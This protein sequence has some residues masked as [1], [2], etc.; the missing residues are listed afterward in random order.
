MVMFFGLNLTY[1]GTALA[2]YVALVCV[3]AGR[4]TYVN[5]SVNDS[6]DAIDYFAMA[7]MSPIFILHKTSVWL[8]ENWEWLLFDALPKI[9]NAIYEFVAKFVRY[10]VIKPFRH[11]CFLVNNIV[12]K[13]GKMIRDLVSPALEWLHVYVFIP[14]VDVVSTV[15]D[16]VSTV[17]QHL[18]HLFRDLTKKLIELTMDLL[19][20]LWNISYWCVYKPTKWMATNVIIPT[21]KLVREFFISVS[22]WLYIHVYTPLS[23]AI[24]ELV[25]DLLNFL[26]DL[27]YW[28]V[29]MPTKWVIINVVVPVIEWLHVYVYIPLSKL[30]LLI[31]DLTKKLAELIMNLLEFISYLLLNVVVP[32]IEWIE[33]LLPVFYRSIEIYVRY[34]WDGIYV[35]ILYP[36]YYWLFYYPIYELFYLR[37]L[38]VL[39]QMMQE[40]YGVFWEFGEKC[41]VAFWT[42]FWE[43][44]A[45][46]VKLYFAIFNGRFMHAWD[47]L[48]NG[49]WA[50][51]DALRS[52]F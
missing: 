22:E 37:L 43:L 29:Y 33:K 7:I 40:L 26:S 48:Y 1:A 34:I 4:F 8:K 50:F 16:V 18:D 2:V 45:E 21:V 49:F 47:R 17:L 46:A 42:L 41:F 39:L 5:K 9:T 3:C 13:F 51:Y 19:E 12:A 24:V 38:Y 36:L 15:V 11:L 6:Y 32:V 20:F 27:S 25:L 44:Y 31:R 10:Y 30:L 28:C 14:M 23:K 35:H 52:K